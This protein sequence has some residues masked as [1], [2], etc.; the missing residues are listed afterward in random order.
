VVR[1]ADG[2]VQTMALEIGDGAIIAIDIV[3]NPDK[4]GH[5]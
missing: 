4:L 3:R 1:D 5:L 2:I